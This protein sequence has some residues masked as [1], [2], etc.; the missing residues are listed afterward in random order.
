MVDVKRGF[1]GNKLIEILH[2]LVIKF[3]C[4][5]RWKDKLMCQLCQCSGQN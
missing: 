4:I 5:P 3:K 2:S 1:K